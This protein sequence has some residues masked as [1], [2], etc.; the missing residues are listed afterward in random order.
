MVLEVVREFGIGAYLVQATELTRD[1]VRTAFT[2]ALFLSA[3]GATLLF[4]VSG[5]AATFYHEPALRRIIPV[6]A[7]N[8]LLVPFSI[9]GMSA[10]RRE[11]AFDSL[12]L[13]GNRPVV[14]RVVL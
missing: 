6:L 10:L 8:F 7:V 5:T 13:I 2:V 1:N 9:Y 3:S 4:A 12:A 14:T 11:M